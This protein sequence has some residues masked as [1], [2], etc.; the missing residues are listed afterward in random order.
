MLFHKFSLQRSPKFDIGSRHFK[1]NAQR[2]GRAGPLS[3]SSFRQRDFAL[4]SVFILQVI[5][6]LQPYRFGP[7]RVLNPDSES[8]LFTSIVCI[9][10]LLH[11][12]DMK[13]F[14]VSLQ[15]DNFRRCVS[16][17]SILFRVFAPN[18]SNL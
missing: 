4:T 10:F 15:T 16:C 6:D 14:L 2:P 18:I 13:G 3:V 11:V 1:T 7:E 12:G 8:E 17:L 9:T 5:A